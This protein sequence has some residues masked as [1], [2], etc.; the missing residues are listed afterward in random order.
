MSW[1]SVLVLLIFKNQRLFIFD[2]VEFFPILQVYIPFDY[3]L[4]FLQWIC[5]SILFV[6]LQRG[7]TIA[8]K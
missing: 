2:L 4:K 8:W 5:A 1:N 3:I 6:I 7:N